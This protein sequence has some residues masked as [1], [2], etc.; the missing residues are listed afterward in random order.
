[1]NQQP[2]DQNLVFSYLEL[3]KAVGIIGVALPFVLA[4]GKLVL[5]GPGLEPTI[6]SYYYTDLG[7]W[8]VGSL[9]AIGVFL[10]STKGYSRYDQVAGLLACIFAVGV[11]LFPMAPD[12]PRVPTQQQVDIGRAHWTFA[13]LLF[14]T[15]ACFSLFLFTRTK[16][17]KGSNPTPQKLKRNIVYRVCGSII[18]GSIVLIPVV[19]HTS[20]AD[21]VQALHPVFWLESLAVEA[22]GVSWLTKGEMILKDGSA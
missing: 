21:K 18:V 13:A 1:M 7:N 12:P 20:I 10:L 22:F 19:T 3:R 4:I 5:Q 11:A 17:D 15:L 14:V 8:F 2:S 6:S 16:R 9:C